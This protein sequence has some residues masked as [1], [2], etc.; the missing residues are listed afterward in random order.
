MLKNPQLMKI[1]KF[2]LITKKSTIANTTGQ[3]LR[4]RDF[5]FIKCTIHPNRYLKTRTIFYTNTKTENDNDIF[6]FTRKLRLIHHYQNCNI[7]DESI[8]K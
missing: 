2:N 6:Q 5:K 7:N 8:V 3:A 4:I 1:V